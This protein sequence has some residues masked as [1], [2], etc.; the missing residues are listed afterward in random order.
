VVAESWGTLARRLSRAIRDRRLAGDLSQPD[1]ARMAK[2]SLRRVQQLEADGGGEN[3]S[4]KA[5]HQIA[6]ALDTTV[7]ELL[8]PDRPKEATRRRA[9]KRS[10]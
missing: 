8:A 7:M 4:L 9:P 10:G 3:P 5:L 2:V 1:L 6:V